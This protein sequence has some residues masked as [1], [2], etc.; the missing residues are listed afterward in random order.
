MNK[1]LWIWIVHIDIYDSWWM[2]TTRYPGLQLAL[3]LVNLYARTTNR[4]LDV[5]S[6]RCPQP[7]LCIDL[8]K[9]SQPSM[10]KMLCMLPSTLDER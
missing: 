9:S 10:A 4:G 8:H 7:G 2:V 6:R 3:V 5:I 1:G